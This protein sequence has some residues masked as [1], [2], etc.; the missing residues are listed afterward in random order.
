MVRI[1]LLLFIFG[2]AV[3]KASNWD[4]ELHK[5]M[6]MDVEEFQRMA[7]LR[8]LSEEFRSFYQNIT[9][10][11]LVPESRLPTQQDLQCYA[12]FAHLTAALVNGS[13]WAYRMFDSWGSL[14]AGILVGHFKDLGH[15][16]ECV[17]IEQAITSNYNLMGKY[18]L[19]QLPLQL[20]M[21]VQT[22]VCFPASC[23]AANMD[24][25]LLR[26]L[27]QLLGVELSADLTFVKERTC[28]TAE[29]EPYD[30]LTVFTIAFLSVL[31]AAV[32]LSTLYDYFLC[33]DQEKLPAILRVFSAR[34]NSR[35]LFRISNNSNPNVVHCL[36]GMRGMSLI[37]VCFGHDYLIGITSPNINFLDVYKWAKSP[38]MVVIYEGVFAVDTFFF[39]SGM[40]VSMVALRSME[41]A[42]GKLNIP[43]MYLHRYL[44]LTPIVAVAIL[45]YLKVLPL[46]ADG[47][48][49]GN[50]NFDNYDSCNENWYWTLLYIQNYAADRICLAQTW[51][52][53]IDM[54]LYIIAPLLLI[55]VYKW[56]T[57]GAA[58]VMLLTLLLAA[59]LF[60]I[61][62]IKNNSLISG[63][64]IDLSQNTHLRASGWL[65]GFLFGY[66]LHTIRGKSIKHS[67]PIV[68]LGWLTSLAL[69]FTCIFAM[70]PYSGANSKA[71]PILNEAF[72]V[73][74][75]RIAWPLG[76]SWV[77]FACMQGYGGLANS[78]LSSPLWQPLSKLSYCVY[79]W[80]LFIQNLNAGRTRVST[81]FSDYDVML[82]FWQ[83]FGFS[84]L[85]AY[86]MYIL[87][88][89][90]FGGLSS[91]ILPNRRAPPT[92]KV[93]LDETDPK[94]NQ[95]GND[96]ERQTPA[97][98]AIQTSERRESASAPPLKRESKTKLEA[99][100]GDAASG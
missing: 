19:A 35:G 42:K 29:R 30:G 4:V 12:E 13:L 55:V 85:L 75:S 72:Y 99:N 3:A 27:K 97:P 16:D 100:D 38:F 22:A 44:R 62:V 79:M 86:V 94:A 23:S 88:E 90:P 26:L 51:Y 21:N 63:G 66:Y 67:S 24:T 41:K 81:Y 54:Q 87:V 37:W 15:Y 40:L 9:L 96:A 60:S 25:L 36:H 93:P 83:D 32:V 20:P 73:S 17:N 76:L 49:F 48:L 61:M 53:A 39:I 6:E 33:E 58:A 47:P 59:Y 80:H 89:A 57:K 50:W 77:V 92:P 1:T 5:G 95:L 28:K 98:E 68:W 64:D 74:L 43:L 82:R 91:L 69:L 84:L 11:D 52:L 14:P 56:G 65:V 34:Y 71:L 18:C 46:M 70:Y 45:V 2:L 8:H 10:S 7:K 78:F 31:G